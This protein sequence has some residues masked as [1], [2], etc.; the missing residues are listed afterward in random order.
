[1]K[2][3]VEIGI[4]G[5]GVSCG[6]PE[7]GYTGTTWA[8][9]VIDYAQQAGL[10]VCS[11][12]PATDISATDP[13]TR[14]KAVATVQR[15]I[16][17]L[18]SSLPGVVFTVH[19]EDYAPLRQPG[20]DQARMESCRRSLEALSST[21]SSLGAYIALENMR[22]RPDASNR[23]G[24]LVD[25]LSE[26]VAGLDTSTV[27]LCFDTGH[28]NI[29]EKSNQAGAFERNAS[30]IIHIHWHDNVGNDDL[31]LV[32][33]KGNIDFKTLF[34]AVRE[35]QYGGMVELEVSMPE[36]DDPL[37]FYKR[38]FQYFLACVS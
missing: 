27:G 3:L 26:I 17:N 15:A 11:H 7:H 5:I 32:P 13:T 35:S 9:R 34:L 31:H 21:A 38:N 10:R 19:P 4:G 1:M 16:T 33:G 8:Q 36:Q 14:K 6:D 23:T 37:S 25:Q 29:S 22:W 28:V 18:G 20:D 24:M 12:A 2:E 30:R